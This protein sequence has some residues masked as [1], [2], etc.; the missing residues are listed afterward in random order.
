MTAD[1]APRRRCSQ[2][3]EEYPLEEFPLYNR[4]TGGRRSMCRKCYNENVRLRYKKVGRQGAV[5]V[6]SSPVANEWPPG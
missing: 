2:C 1:P 5:E 4:R 3:G 6:V